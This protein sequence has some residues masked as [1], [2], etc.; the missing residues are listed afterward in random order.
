MSPRNP[1][2]PG[3]GRT[4]DREGALRNTR[5]ARLLPFRSLAELFPRCILSRMEPAAAIKALARETGFDDCRIAAAAEARHADTFRE[6]IADGCHGDMAWME[7][8]RAI[9]PDGLRRT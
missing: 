6:W 4:P 1:E 2:I 3:R 5:G 9:N 7:R 8:T